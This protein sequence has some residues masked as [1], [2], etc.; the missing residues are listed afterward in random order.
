MGFAWFIS[1]RYLRLGQKQAFISLMSLL[2]IIGVAVG[3]MALV[4]VIGVMAGFE[5]DLRDR[6]LAMQAHITL[7]PRAD[8]DDG[9]TGVR[10]VEQIEGVVAATAFIESQVMLRSA[11]GSTGALLRGVEP[12]KAAAVVG[13]QVDFSVLSRSSSD[14][15]QPQV[16]GILLGKELATLL[17]VVAGDRVFLV[18]P[19]GMLSPVGHVPAMRPFQVVATFASGVYE[20]DGAIAFVT[21]ADARHVLRLG[22]RIT[23]IQVRVADIYMADRVGQAIGSSLGPDWDVRSW[24]STNRSLFSALKLEKAVMFIILALIVSVAALNIASALIMT[25]MEKAKD[26]AILKAIGASD[27]T[28]GRIFMGNGLAI[29]IFGIL[30]GTGLGLALCTLLS[31]FD[32]IRL[33]GDVYYITRLPVRLKAL[34]VAAIAVAAVLICLGATIYPARQAAQL[35]PLETIR[36]G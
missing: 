9:Q 14:A 31:H 35:N 12:D 15:A 32:L 20:Y 29:G 1:R 26:I 27:Q 23:G 34:D 24:T 8:M 33:P 4:V 16:P 17:G 13:D 5:A 2:S 18:A 3:V 11:T 21:L 28:I 25:V 30:I 19:G 22:D 6:L 36:R 7:T 10:G